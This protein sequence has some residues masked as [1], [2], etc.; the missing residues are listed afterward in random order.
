MTSVVGSGEPGSAQAA[1]DLW[2]LTVL[3]EQARLA[4]S[5]LLQVWQWEGDPPDTA[6][7]RTGEVAEEVV[8]GD[9]Q[10]ALF[11]GILIDRILRAPR[12]KPRDGGSGVQRWERANRL[13]SLLE[14]PD[15]SQL[16]KVA[17][18]R[19]SMEHL[20]ERMDRVIADRRIASV[21]DAAISQG[22]LWFKSVDAEAIAEDETAM[23][24]VAMRIFSPEMGLLIYDEDHIDLWAWEAAL[25]GLLSQIRG[26]QDGVVSAL[27]AE[28]TRF[29]MAKPEIWDVAHDG[30]DRRARILAIREQVRQRGEFLLRPSRRPGTVDYVATAPG[31]QDEAI[32]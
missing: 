29:G 27:R 4:L 24:H 11:A 23:R 32:N 17:A 3:G 5:H 9:L 10:G 28:R 30:A 21:T 16:L 15:D 20:D 25:H 14:V 7:W 12:P 26:A 19:N 8:W 6:I 18:V 13:R 1:A 2:F 22:G 31:G